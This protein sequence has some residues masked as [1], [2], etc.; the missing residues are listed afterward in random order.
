MAK[1]NRGKIAK[2]VALKTGTPYRGTCP[3]CSKTGIKLLYTHQ[4]S[5]GH[6]MKVCK[7]CTNK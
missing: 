6:Q 2:K 1:R 7:N 3:L 5:T 4:T